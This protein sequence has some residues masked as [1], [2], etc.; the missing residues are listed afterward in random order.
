M[1]ISRSVQISECFKSFFFFTRPYLVTHRQKD[2]KRTL[3]GKAGVVVAE[4]V[5]GQ[6]ILY[7]GTV[8]LR[9]LVK[10]HTCD[11]ISWYH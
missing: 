3:T 2:K 5:M 9:R 7:E 1:L 10:G 8:P 4:V 11:V 6:L